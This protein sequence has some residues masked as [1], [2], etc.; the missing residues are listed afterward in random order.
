MAAKRS[1]D[2]R[3]RGVDTE[4]K[5]SP[6]RRT[7]TASELL[8]KTFE[9]T[10]NPVIAIDELGVIVLVSGGVENLLG[11]QPVELLGQSLDV[12]LTPEHQV[13]YAELIRRYFEA[14]HERF[15]DAVMGITALHRDGS[16]R[17]VD[18]SLR[19]LE[20][21]GRS[22]A[23]AEIRDSIERRS[24]ESDSILKSLFESTEYIIT[25]TNL[26]GMVTTWNRAA[27]HLFGYSAKEM[28]GQHFS[29]LVSQ[30][31]MDE[32]VG[33]RDQT[34]HTGVKSTSTLNWVDRKGRAFQLEVDRIAIHD[35]D[36]QTIGLTNIGRD[37]TDRL[38]YEQKLKEL[39]RRIHSAERIESLG[40]LAGGIAHDFNNS[41]FLI[42]NYAGML[43]RKLADMP[44]ASADLEKIGVAAAQA[45]ALTRRLLIFA[46]GELGNARVVCI[47]REVASFVELVGSTL[48]DDFE[49]EVRTGSTR[50]QVMLDSGQFE[51]V[52]LNVVLNCRDA[53]PD[54]GRITITTSN[55]ELGPQ[56]SSVY[57]SL[58]EG[59]YVLIEI[60][61][62]GGGMES[63]VLEHVFEPFF[64]TKSQ[65][66]GTGLGLSMAFG[67][68][69]HAGGDI[70]FFSEI[71]VGTT[72]RIM[73]P[74]SGLDATTDSLSDVEEIRGRGETILVVD[75]VPA[76]GDMIRL[77]LS[78]N[79]Y[80]VRVTASAMESINLFEVDG[81]QI[82]LLL[83]D[84]TM[85]EKSGREVADAFK[86]LDPTGAVLFI[87]GF[88]NPAVLS[89]V[90]YDYTLLA[91]PFSEHEL[92]AAVR[93]I[94]DR[95]SKG[96]VTG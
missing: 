21:A 4:S 27:E 5:N 72:C 33:A 60:V 22:Y 93:R 94:L 84:V 83:T 78:S 36:G 9:S 86:A 44:E 67:M 66:N 7:A 95:A 70:R 80:D 25:S 73:L 26:E 50:D 85:P 48:G 8:W 96:P 91:K 30:E 69:T 68:V 11:F 2:S 1:N 82:D 6:S 34:L 54:G 74:V 59:S 45:S 16:A 64:T 77:M 15:M 58:N 41:L 71:G 53:M 55:V 32:V 43:K 92:L 76:I 57:P 88:A 47:N 52:L 37:I 79:G 28:L 63:S 3:D 29:V 81:K 10:P 56:D 39:E 51:R 24:L 23:V 62:T 12:M 14:P 18:I 35:K 17:P 89:D 40:T 65:E 46:R 38:A 75:D 61:D 90:L 87:S 31:N 42:L 13:R 19:R 49:L 20:L